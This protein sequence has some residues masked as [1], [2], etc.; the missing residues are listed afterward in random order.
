[1]CKVGA[2]EGVRGEIATE[3][4][5]Q[6]PQPWL[7]LGTSLPGPQWLASGHWQ[8]GSM[9]AMQRRPERLKVM[10]PT[11]LINYSLLGGLSGRQHKARD[12]H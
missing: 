8:L 12:A 9:Q 3:S 6:L 4:I 2:R 11:T 7:R 1:M 5:L 10:M